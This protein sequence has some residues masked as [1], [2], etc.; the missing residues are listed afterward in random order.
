MTEFSE[1]FSGALPSRDARLWAMW[2]HLGS[3]SGF[4]GIPFGSILVP[5]IIWLL[6]RDSDS[7]I[8]AHGRESLNFQVTLIIYFI[9]AGILCLVLIGFVL[10]AV[11]YI[12]GLVLTIQAAIRANDGMP[13]R[14]PFTIRLFS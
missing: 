7:F 14:Y 5:A 11:L 9:I 3:L 6:K 2:C 12:G 13:Y 8:D 1:E 10:L 4:I